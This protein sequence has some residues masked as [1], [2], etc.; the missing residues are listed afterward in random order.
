MYC[1][2]I[3]SRD[4]TALVATVVTAFVP[5]RTKAQQHLMTIC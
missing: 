5:S 4:V 1:F 2:G 3:E